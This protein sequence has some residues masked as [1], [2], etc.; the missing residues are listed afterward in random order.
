M[1]RALGAVTTWDT[2]KKMTAAANADE[3]ARIQAQA[4]VHEGDA[5]KVKVAPHVHQALPRS[6]EDG[7]AHRA[8]HGEGA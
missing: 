8:L 7:V 4:Q 2:F 5:G 1:K 6:R 3:A